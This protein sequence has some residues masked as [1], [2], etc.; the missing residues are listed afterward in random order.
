LVE[1]DEYNGHGADFFVRK[2]LAAIFKKEPRIDVV[3]LACTHYPILRSK[4]SEYLPLGVKLVAQGEIV[5]ASLARYLSRH[6]EIEQRCSKNG[7]RDFYTT[8]ST[9]DFDYH[10]NTFFGEETSSHHLDLGSL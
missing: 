8:D 10:A 3:L 7:R 4:I 6:P 5:A 2:N 1:N 9:E